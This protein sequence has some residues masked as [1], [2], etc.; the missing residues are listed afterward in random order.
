MIRRAGEPSEVVGRVPSDS[1][2][3]NL[4]EGQSKGVGRLRSCGQL[5]SEKTHTLKGEVEREGKG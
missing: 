1:Q 2:W 4:P 5:M 3:K